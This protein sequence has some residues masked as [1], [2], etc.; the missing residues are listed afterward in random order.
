M[1]PEIALLRL[2]AKT[3][4]LPAEQVMLWRDCMWWGYAAAAG[5]AMQGVVIRKVLVGSAVNGVGTKFSI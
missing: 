3:P 1:A 2:V 5:V 4:E